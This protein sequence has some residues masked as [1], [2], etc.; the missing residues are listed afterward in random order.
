MDRPIALDGVLMWRKQLVKMEILASFNVR[1]V[2]SR[3]FFLYMHKKAGMRLPMLGTLEL[4]G[5]LNRLMFY[6]FS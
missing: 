2:R 4:V 3:P 5:K 1:I 6:V